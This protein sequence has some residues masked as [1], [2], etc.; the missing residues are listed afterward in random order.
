M[1]LQQRPGRDG[2]GAAVC[3]L[4]DASDVTYVIDVTDVIYVSYETYNL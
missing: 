4:G 3:L 1:V 2:P